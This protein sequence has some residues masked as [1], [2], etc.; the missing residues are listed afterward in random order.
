M[1][2]VDA[3]DVNAGRFGYN[4]RQHLDFE[5]EIL[6][7]HE[8]DSKYPIVS[9]ASII[10][11]VHR[12]AIVAGIGETLGEDVGSG[13]P[14]DPVTREFLKNYYKKHRRLPDC[15]RKSWKTANAIVADCLQARLFEF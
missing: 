12:D 2:Y 3:C 9:A 11:K 13:Y 14:T 4:I 10:A 15:A 5:V 8:A 7:C 1:A 6:S